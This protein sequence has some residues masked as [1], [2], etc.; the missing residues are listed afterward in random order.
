[1]EW[2]K[3]TISKAELEKKQREYMEAAMNMAKRAGN[4]AQNVNA[5]PEPVTK[6]EIVEE[7][8]EEIDDLTG[9]IEE[10]REKAE[11][12]VEE[13]AEETER[14]TGEITEE[15]EDKDGK[16]EKFGVFN[17]DELVTAIENG[18]VSSEGLKQAAEILEE[19]TRKTETM[20]KLVEEQE[21]DED[22]FDSGENYGLNGFINRHN[23]NC[24][25]CGNESDAQSPG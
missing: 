5:A 12:A 15:I 23:S 4:A 19:M 16:D 9:V 6:A 8:V 7:I 17:T 22:I 10:I 2:I 1:M 20:R 18:E 13:T 3:N 14:I 24:R 25:G 21:N 11:E